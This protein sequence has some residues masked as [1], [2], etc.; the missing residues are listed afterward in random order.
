MSRKQRHARRQRE[1]LIGRNFLIIMILILSLGAIALLSH[2]LMDDIFLLKAK[3]DMRDVA[4]TISGMDI[5][6]PQTKARLSDLE[7]SYNFYFEMYYPRD[8]LIYTTDANNSIF[9][10][11]QDDEKK[12]QPRYMPILDREEV[13]DVSYFEMRREFYTTAKYIVYGTQFDS[14]V[15]IEIYASI[16]IIS[17]N[18]HTTNRIVLYVVLF[19][20]VLMLVLFSVQ[21]FGVTIPI[22]KINRITK[23]L[24][25]MDFDTACPPFRLR[26]IDELGTSINRLSASLDMTLKTLRRRN[27]QLEQDIENEKELLENRKQ[28]IANASH[29]LKTP[30]AIIQGYAEGLKYGIYDSNRDECYDV[31]LEEAQKM[32]KLVIRLMEINRISSANVAPDYATFS[33]IRQIGTFVSQ[34]RSIFAKN[35]ITAF[36]NVDEAY[37]AVADPVLFERVLSNYVSNAVSHCAGKKEIR[38]TCDEVDGCYRIRVFNTGKPIA[39]EDLPNIWT[40]FYRADKS[41]SRAEGRFGLGLPIVAASQ[42]AQKMKYGVENR[43]DGVEFWFD[44]RKSTGEADADTDTTDEKA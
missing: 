35:G 41:H 9:G 31:I 44:V 19:L 36:C 37:T 26:E 22:N 21:S 27:A 25:Q 3:H 15:A 6:D 7:A 43:A 34:C 11:M 1:S 42:E 8:Q 13:D 40:S 18:A 17:S 20:S 28:F 23:R 33:L 29:E 10:E 5:T 16:D 2:V 39:E 38:I 14:G 30:I 24:A 4:D 12:L 32:N